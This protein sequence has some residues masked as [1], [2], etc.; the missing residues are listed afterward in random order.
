M[1]LYIV[2]PRFSADEAVS[3]AMRSMSSAERPR[4]LRELAGERET[5]PR[6]RDMERHLKGTHARLVTRRRDAPATGT[7]LVDMS[8]HEAEQLRAEQPDALVLRDQPI[9]LIKPRKTLDAEHK[10]KLGKANLWHLG[11]IGLTAARKRARPF[12]GTGEGVTVAVL[13]TGV[14]ASHPEI[15]HAVTGAYTFD[16]EKWKAK[17]ARKSVDTEGHG[18]H[19]SGLVAGKKVG[20]AP[21]ASVISA[22]MLPGGRG[23]LS[24]FVLALEWCASQPQ[25]QIV[26]VSAGIRGYLPGMHRVVADLLAVGLLP[27][28]ASGNEGRNKTRSPG[29]YAE[30]LSVGAVDKRSK[31]S[32]FSS[33]GTIVSD[34]HQYKVPDLVAPGEGV[35]SSVMGGGYE[36]WDGTS[37]ATPI[38]SGIAALVIE[39]HPKITIGQ[40]QEE[41]LT[42]CKDLKQDEDRQGKGLVQVK[43]AV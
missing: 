19:V 34:Q 3:L 13:D 11:L 32:D 18:T 38:V 27:V 42:T 17:R 26:N 7:V 12:K 8:D 15:A 2:R 31:V 43:A 10:D 20:V 29:N 21:G 36:A 4:Q 30:V 23:K 6:T 1:P 5:D 14:D 28:V 9:G 25:I 37:M 35:Y 41:L 22:V 33:G 40:L 39:R 16:A 24:D